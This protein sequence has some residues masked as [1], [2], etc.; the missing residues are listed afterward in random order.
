V[1]AIRADRAAIEFR[2][3][4][5]AARD[6]L[7]NALG[8]KITVQEGAWNCSH[9]VTTERRRPRSEIPPTSRRRVLYGAAPVLFDLGLNQL[10]EM[11]LEPVMCALF[12]GAHE[13]RIAGHI[14]GEDRGEAADREHCFV[15]AVD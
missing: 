13:A 10:A 4:P 3:F 7:V 12:V 5:P 9:F 6:E 11:R 2:G 1:E 8:D 14:G 15:R